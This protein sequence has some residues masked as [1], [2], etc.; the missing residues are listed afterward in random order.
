MKTN[1]S[2]ANAGD[3]IDRLES[4]ETIAARELPFQ[5]NAAT[6]WRWFSGKINGICLESRFVGGRRLLSVRMLRDWQQKLGEARAAKAAERAKKK[7][8]GSMKRQKAA[9]AGAVE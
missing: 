8:A 5:P 6:W 4:I 9:A 1:S 7:V 2:E 3:D